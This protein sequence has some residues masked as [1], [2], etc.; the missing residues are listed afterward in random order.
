MFTKQMLII[1]DEVKI[2]EMYRQIFY[3]IGYD[4]VTAGNADDALNSLVR[5][6]F[7]VVLLDINMPKV[8]GSILFEEMKVSHKNVKV[9][10]SSVYS[11]NE[12]QER[13]KDADGYFDKSD[14]KDVLVSLVTSLFI[15]NAMTSSLKPMKKF[16]NKNGF[17]LI[18]IIVVL[19]IVGI[20][21]T[22]A[23]PSLFANVAKSRVAE[24][25]AGLSTY[26]S[27]TEGCVQAHYLTAATSCTWAALGLTSAS[28][29]FL[30]TYGTAP[31]N[32]AYTYGITAKNTAYAGDTITLTRG[33]LSTNGY[34]CAGAGNY[35]GAC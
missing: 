10:V 30:Y 32:S 35:A 31:A 26:K 18:E 13:I 1:D 17:T 2:R 25:L 14:S 27:Q 9:V 5:N 21:A 23:L 16:N 6:K 8:D 3:S 12:Q 15:E 7:D 22:I 34:T 29:N 24:G 4:V 28:G 11:I 33:S 19:I 20:L